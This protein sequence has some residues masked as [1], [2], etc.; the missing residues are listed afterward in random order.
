MLYKKRR[1][2]SV[3]KQL[4]GILILNG[5]VISHLTTIYLT[6]HLPYYHLSDSAVQK[7][8]YYRG[9]FLCRGVPVRYVTTTLHRIIKGWISQRMRRF[10]FK[11]ICTVVRKI[12]VVFKPTEHVSV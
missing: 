9:V 5:P 4:K 8:I 11:D 12:I 2:T 7:E 6:M 3:I 10:Q 1:K